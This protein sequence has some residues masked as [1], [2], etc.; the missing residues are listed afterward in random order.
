[1]AT[2]SKVWNNKQQIKIDK[3]RQKTRWEKKFAAEE[4]PTKML[5]LLLKWHGNR[6]LKKIEVKNTF[7]EGD[8]FDEDTDLSRKRIRGKKIK[9]DKNQKKKKKRGT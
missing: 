9:I 4:R 7:T 8:V 2:N 3:R 6:D 1:M 5:T